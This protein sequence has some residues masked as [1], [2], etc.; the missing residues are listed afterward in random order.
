MLAALL[1]HICLAVR[2]LHDLERHGAIAM[3]LLIPMLGFILYFYLFFIK[4]TAGHNYYGPDPLE[5]VE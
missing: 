4:G 1:A 2:R 5:R 3:A